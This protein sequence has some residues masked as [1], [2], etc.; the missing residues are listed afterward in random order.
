MSGVIEDSL[1]GQDPEYYF[2]YFL[3]VNVTG[4]VFESGKLS[5]PLA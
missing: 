1:K 2:I 3:L 4:T 5:D